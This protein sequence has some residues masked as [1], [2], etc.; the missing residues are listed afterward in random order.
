MNMKWYLLSDRAD[1]LRPLNFIIGGRG[2]GKTY[3]TIDYVLNQGRP[4]IYLR[5]TDTQLQECATPF[6]NPF[7]RWNTDHDRNVQIITQR[8]HCMIY[9]CNGEGEEKKLIGYAVALST[10]EN[11]RG[12]DLSD[13]EYVIFDEFCEKKTLSFQQFETFANFYETVNRNREILGDKPLQVF[14]LSNAQKLNN[15]ILAGYGVIPIIERMIKNQKEDFVS[16]L[17]YVSM[18]RSEVSEAKKNTVNYKLTEGTQYYQEAL[19]NMFAHDSFAN[20]CRRPVNE[21][22]PVCCIDDLYIWK[23]KS[24]SRYYVCRSASNRVPAYNSRDNLTAFLRRYGMQLRLAAADGK[25]DY[26]EFLIKSQIINL[27]R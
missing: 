20:I 4:F 27:L 22:M 13:V 1:K 25:I 7:K 18:P 15:P 6:G 2:I 23:H 8:K 17:L 19:E 11:L 3:G 26:A 16:E 21:Y 5:N 12:V 24:T 14:L 9:D 10:F